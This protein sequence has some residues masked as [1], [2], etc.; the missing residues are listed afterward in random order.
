MEDIKYIGKNLYKFNLKYN[1][2]YCLVCGTSITNKQVNL[3]LKNHSNILNKRDLNS[4]KNTI[5]E[6]NIE[7]LD[8]KKPLDNIEYFKELPIITGY[9]C[10]FCSYRTSSY[11]KIRVHLN[12]EHNKTIKE[13][14][15]KDILIKEAFFSP[16]FK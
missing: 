2:L 15:N 16:F 7:K 14:K 11:K 4:I 12:K 1:F 9:N 8:I 6:L 10:T 13:D 5:K 3:H